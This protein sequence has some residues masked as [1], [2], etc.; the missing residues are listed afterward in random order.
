MSKKSEKLLI[1]GACGFLGGHLLNMAGD[2]G[3]DA[4]GLGFGALADDSLIRLDITD[5]NAVF[6]AVKKI[7][8]TVIIH[9][10]A[11]SD[12][13]FCE[14]N[15]VVA[16]RVNVDGTLNLAKAAKEIKAHFIYIS[17]DLV[18]DG[19]RGNYSES[20]LANP[21]NV[22]GKTK[23]EGEKVTLETNPNFTVARLS[24]CYGL[25]INK[26]QNYLD[27]F[28]ASLKN[29]E[30]QKLFVDEFRTPIY[31]GH[32]CHYL[33]GLA[34]KKNKG[35]FHLAGKEKH[36]RLDFGLKVADIFKSDSG[37][38]SDLI[39]PSLREEFAPHRPKDT[40]L[41]S[42]K[43]FL[44]RFTKKLHPPYSQVIEILDYI[45]F[46]EDAHIIAKNCGVFRLD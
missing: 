46:W 2:F 30:E 31:V 8:P 37:L 29:G 3:F 7:A 19:I 6:E 45:E 1:T 17:T 16:Q 39:K 23:Y 40:S 9:C 24:W 41:V 4:V 14:K 34:K 27:K 43:V 22:Y 11:I 12:M 20:D 28:I 15:E 18:F 26:S 42:K 25:S 32:A 35:V 38:D 44:R 13:A 36:S 21:I 5:K 33:F 10:A